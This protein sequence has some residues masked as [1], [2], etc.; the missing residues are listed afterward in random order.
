MQIPFSDLEIE[1]GLSEYQVLDE[2][3]QHLNGKIISPST[4]RIKYSPSLAPLNNAISGLSNNFSLGNYPNPFNPSTTIQYTLSQPE[5]VKLVVYDILGKEVKT[6][7]NESQGPGTHNVVFNAGNLSSGI[8]F[9]SITA[10]SF[11]QIKKMM[12]LK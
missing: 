11:H 12:L 8:Y 4:G 6:L 5:N 7:V 2:Y 10:G 1:T 3:V 9:Y